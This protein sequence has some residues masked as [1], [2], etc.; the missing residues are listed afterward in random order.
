MNTKIKPYS[1]WPVR[2]LALLSVI[3]LAACGAASDEGRVLGRGNNE[4]A[5]LSLDISPSEIGEGGSVTLSW[6]SSNVDN[7]V[8]SGDWSGNKSVS[9]SQTLT[10]LIADSR[11]T[12]QCSGAGGTVSRQVKVT[13]TSQQ[14]N[15]VATLSWTPPT[16]N[17]D[18]TPLE[19]LSGFRIYYGTASGNY[20]KTVDVDAGLTEYVVENLSSGTWYFV[21]TAYN[22]LGIESAPSDEVSKTFN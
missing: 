11:F 13:V 4:A 18:N 8:A 16:E 7:C 5:A 6:N 15:G 1:A 14:G 9:G 3:T 2:L 17:T 20:S 22:S 12:L 19:D 10:G 21:V